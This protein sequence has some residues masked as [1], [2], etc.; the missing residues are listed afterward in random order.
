MT[1]RNGMLQ[2]TIIIINLPL[3]II[4]FFFSSIIKRSSFVKF[5]ECFLVCSISL[6]FLLRK[7]LNRKA[8]HCFKPFNCKLQFSNFFIVPNDALGLGLVDIHK[9]VLSLGKINLQ[10]CKSCLSLIKFS[11]SIEVILG[12][13]PV[14]LGC[15]LIVSIAGFNK[16]LLRIKELSLDVNSKPLKFSSSFLLGD[17]CLSF[18][19]FKLN[20][21]GLKFC[22]LDLKS[23]FLFLK[24][25]LG[26][27]YL[28]SSKLGLNL[29]ELSFSG[30]F[31]SLGLLSLCFGCLESC[32]SISQCKLGLGISVVKSSD[33]RKLLSLG[34]TSCSHRRRFNLLHTSR[35]QNQ[36]GKC[37]CE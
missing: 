2:A 8:S 34:L 22:L 3:C 24:L 15:C 30:D 13:L 18:E 21:L 1:S 25:Y 26:N 33:G 14:I 37:Q 35:Q 28:N 20:E 5:L 23:H 17:F 31:E 16:G 9:I 29:Y 27:L 10:V 19:S 4:V 6:N 11:A 36:A 7:L 32:F 12:D